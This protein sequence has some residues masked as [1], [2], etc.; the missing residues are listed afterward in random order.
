M[1]EQVQNVHEACTTRNSTDGHE[2]EGARR[3]DVQRY[4]KG[5]RD[6]ISGADAVAGVIE[7]R[8]QRSLPALNYWRVPCAH[9]QQSIMVLG[10]LWHA[11]HLACWLHADVI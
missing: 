9:L 7:R 1:Q 3:T 5:D 8:H 10:L 6:V 4:K 2:S 11:S